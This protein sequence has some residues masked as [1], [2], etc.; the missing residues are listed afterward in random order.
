MKKL[1]TAVDL[2]KSYGNNVVAS[3][4]ASSVSTELPGRKLFDDTA[5]SDSSKVEHAAPID[6]EANFSHPRK[7]EPITEGGPPPATQCC[8][9]EVESISI[10]R[11]T[12]SHSIG[13]SN[14]PKNLMRLMILSQH[15]RNNRFKL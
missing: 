13:Q 8:P 10:K 7:F 5:D 2:I 11:V 12:S 6:P 14:V 9:K 3:G 15:M 1:K 4:I